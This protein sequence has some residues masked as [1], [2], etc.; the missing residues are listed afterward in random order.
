MVRE[1]AARSRTLMN[2]SF[3]MNPQP[4]KSFISRFITERMG[5]T[6]LTESQVIFLMILDGESGVSLKEM[7]ERV[8][9][10]K[11]LTTRAVKHLLGNGF[12]ENI[13]ESGKEHSIILTEKG[14]EAK[15]MAAAAFDELFG[16]LLD[17]L[18]DEEFTVMEQALSKIKHK[19]EEL[20]LKEQFP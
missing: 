7:T 3:D 15:R 4:F 13:A 2:G 8:G 18:T 12:V 14:T 20:S 17:D 1:N 6:G 11:S 10:H 16:L 19:M 5:E 9:V